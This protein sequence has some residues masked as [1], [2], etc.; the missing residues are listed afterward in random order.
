GAGWP[1]PHGAAA[2]AGGTVAV[3]LA[4]PPDPQPVWLAVAVALA[5]VTVG[6]VLW[7]LH[8]DSPRWSIAITGAASVW[9][10]WA[11]LRGEA[12]YEV[13]WDSDLVDSQLS[14]LAALVAALAFAVGWWLPAAGW[15]G[16]LLAALALSLAPDFAPAVVEGRSLPLA[17]L[18]LAAGLLWHRR[19]PTPSLVWLGPAVAMGLLPS[20]L[21]AWGAPWALDLGDLS[22]T[23]QLVRLA[24]LLVAGVLAVVLGARS[25]LGGLLIPAA[26]ALLITAGAQIWGGLATLPRFLALA[27]A[28]T[29]LVLAGA[30]IEWLRSQGRRMRNWV[31]GLR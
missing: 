9:I 29:L 11:L 28:G 17:A 24:G 10:G 3:V 2:L 19:G 14:L 1:L 6:M 5:G 13:R 8:G 23:G 7:V 20:A 16:T 31:Q 25:R 12:P 18:L 21:A 30:R 4:L 15:V 27:S 22:T 26:L